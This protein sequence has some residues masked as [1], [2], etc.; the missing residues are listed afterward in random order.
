MARHAT[1]LR[2]TTIALDP[3]AAVPLYRQLYDA[4]HA[5]I[6]SGQLG[7]GSRLP[8]TRTLARELGVA[9]GTVAGAFEQLLAEGY[10]ES[11]AR[12]GAYVAH[13][14]PDSLLQTP[15]G[16]RRDREPAAPAAR[17]LSQRGAATLDALRTGRTWPVASDGMR[18]NGSG[19]V[20]L[21]F[22]A[23]LPALDAFPYH[24]GYGIA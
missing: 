14:V 10:L 9:R 22:D 21:A 5:I 23:A 6:L 17:A 3:A 20:P 8:S 12:G 1:A 18:C 24:I 2:F 7:A 13:A 19:S 4:L 16:P 15:S 11:E